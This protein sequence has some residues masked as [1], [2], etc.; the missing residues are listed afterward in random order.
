MW[1]D[2][3][4]ICGKHWTKVVTEI[5]TMACMGIFTDDG[6]TNISSIS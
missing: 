3:F 5:N 4:R 6:F 1:D 2:D